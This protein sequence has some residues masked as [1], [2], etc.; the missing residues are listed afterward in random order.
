[1]QTVAPVDWT[2]LGGLLS[3]QVAVVTGGGRG[4]GEGIAQGLAGVG[5]TVAIVDIDIDAAKTAVAEINDRG[6][7]AQEY[8]ADITDPAE[9]QRVAAEIKAQ[10]GEVSILVNNAGILHRTTIDEPDFLESFEQQYAVNVRGSVNMAHAFVDQIVATKG[11]ITNV[12]S[13]ACFRSPPRGTGYTASKGAV[14]QL[15]RGL[16]AEL[17][18][19]GVRVNG[20]APNAML[21]RMTLDM[22]ND[23]A[24][25]DAVINRTPLRKFGVPTDLAGP[26]IFLSSPLLAGHVSG[27]MLPVDGGVT[28]Q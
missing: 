26:V 11:S 1:M 21:T 13:T 8:Q 5:A 4:N 7:R 24:I 9:C 12:G 6:G 3:G 28:A 17:G 16:A 25:R 20:V 15:T 14:L 22:Q 10:F 19:R 18:P 2:S 23:P 27:V